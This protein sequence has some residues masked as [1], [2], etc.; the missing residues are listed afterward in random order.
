MW[1]PKT[2]VELLH[3]PLQKKLPKKNIDLST[4]N[5]SGPNGRIV[6]K[7]L[8]PKSDSREP[9]LV[10]TK[11]VVRNPVSHAGDKS[12]PVSKMRSVIARRVA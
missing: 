12:V 8:I 4:I 6:K 5:G 10:T 2:R 3:L 1:V 11:A 7:D 9:S